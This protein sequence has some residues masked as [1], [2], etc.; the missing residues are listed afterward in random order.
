MTCAETVSAT[1]RLGE[2]RFL[3]RSWFLTRSRSFFSSI[4][5]VGAVAGITAGAVAGI[6][7]AAVIAALLA[8]WLS[9]KGYDYYMAQGDMSASGL[10]N[11][12]YFAN[13]TTMAGDFPATTPGP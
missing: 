10:T 2:W 8:F 6:V 13:N 1:I 9:K 3:F 12:P 7:V 5:G 4:I 11:N